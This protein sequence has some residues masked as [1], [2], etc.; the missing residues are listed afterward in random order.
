MSPDAS[1]GLSI[2]RRQLEELEALSSQTLHD[3]NTVAGTERI[4]KW[5]ARTT[6]LITST[7]GHQQGT[8][9]ADIQPGPSFTNDLLEEFT[10]LVDCYRTALLTLATQLPQSPLPRS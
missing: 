7:V 10:D 6:A 2:V 4:T 9:F 5:K 3:L 1:P 8:A